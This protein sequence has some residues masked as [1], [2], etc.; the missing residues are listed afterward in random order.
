[1]NRIGPVLAVIAARGGSKGL[2]RKNVL[3]LGG[4]PMVAWSVTAA[5]QARRIGRLIISTDDKDIADAAQDAGC[6][7]PFLRPAE[8]ATD[9]APIESA[10]I[11]AL[12]ALSGDWG[13]IVLLQATSPFRSGADID[14]C[15]DLLES[16][17]APSVVSMTKSPKPPHWMYTLDS[18]GHM[19]SVLANPALAHRRQDLPSTY[20]PN[21]AIYAARVSWFRQSKSFY[22]PDTIGFVM[23][24]EHSVD[25]DTPLDFTYAQAL[26][27][28]GIVSQQQE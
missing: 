27:T 17:G 23:P 11:H 9:E 7:V 16:S 14:A 28:A 20:I 6:E 22:A 10:L 21:G 19:V 5:R 2:S 26:L 8:L 3:N 13:V 25:I 1:M 24:P 12:D 4:K 18:E 15:L